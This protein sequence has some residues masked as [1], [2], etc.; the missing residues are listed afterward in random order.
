MAI[1]T[2]HKKNPG[3]KEALIHLFNDLTGIAPQKKQRILT[4][5]K[6]P[7]I[8]IPNTKDHKNNISHL[9]A[10]C[11]AGQNMN[12]ADQAHLEAFAEQHL[13]EKQE[14]NTH[15]PTSQPRPRRR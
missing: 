7:K 14:K 9:F 1:K 12:P 5:L 8:M 13:V 6:S 4:S 3:L 10:L 11:Y 15:T 2:K